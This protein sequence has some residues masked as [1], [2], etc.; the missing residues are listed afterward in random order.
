M[1]MNGV[2]GGLVGITAGADQMGPTSAIII[3][4]VGGIVVVCVLMQFCCWLFIF[5]VYWLYD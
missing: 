2:L 5:L 4:A 3:G 1:F